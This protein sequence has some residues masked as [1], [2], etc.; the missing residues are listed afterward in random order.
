MDDMAMLGVENLPGPIP[1]GANLLGDGS[2]ATFKAWAPAAREVRLRFNF[3]QDPS[4][5]WHHQREARLQPLQGGMWAGFVP[6]I[7]HGARYLFYVVGPAGGGEGVKRDPYARE[8]SD[9]PAWPDSHCLLIDPA[10]FTWH[11]AGY[12]PPTFHELIVYQLHVGTWFIPEGR[13]HGT[14]LDVLTRLPY[15]Q[16][17]GINAIQPLPVVEF[18]TMFS[19]GYNGVDY[20]SPEMDYGVG[21][22]DPALDAYLATANRL[23]HEIRPD[24]PAYARRDIEGTANQLRMLVDLCHLY[25]IAVLFDVVYNHA[26]GNFTK[27]GMY[28]FDEQPRDSQ[29]NSL[30]F[31]DRGWAGGLVFAYWKDEVKQ[32]LIDNA[33]FYLAEYHAD[34]FRYD[35]VSVIRNEGG[36]HGWLLCRYITDTCRFVKPEA[37]HIAEHWPVDGQIVQPTAAGGAGF[38]AMQHDGLREAVRG[39]VGQAA[40][41]GDAFVDMQRIGRAL[42]ES[43]LRDAWRAVQCTENHDLVYS[44]RGQRI[45]R[46]ADPSDSR[47]WYARS[48]ARVALALTVT[49]PGIAQLF[50]GQEFLEDKQWHDEPGG[51]LQ[52]WW[53]GLGEDHSMADFLRF[54]QD[55]IGV[56]R[57]HRGL[58]AAGCHVYHVHDDNRVLALHRWVPDA[59]YDVLVVASLS[60]TSYYRYRLGFPLA[61]YWREVFNSDAYDHWPNP[62]VAG[63]GGG[64]HAGAPGMHGLAASADIV[65]PANGLL[66]L[67]R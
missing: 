38:D 2:G 7:R 25:G 36:E 65:I 9:V 19:L 29:N 54:S 45:A 8:L 22:G 15:L 41:G 42:S 13:S 47:S 62:R 55:L 18:P 53:N 43:R 5:T 63:N 31:T 32:F 49:A 48:R 56:R 35:E 59:G 52:I 3:V 60:E 27:R 44:G 24:L 40:A 50:M 61:G 34:G 20:F 66:V 64:V 21:R 57:H 12:R 39:A 30:Y 58:S 4:G 37:I 6:G 23:L 26:G 51:P 33:L 28:F 14:F 17:L 10:R 1:L 46:L 11:D 16:A 67:A